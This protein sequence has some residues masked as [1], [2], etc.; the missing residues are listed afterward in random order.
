MTVPTRITA[1]WLRKHDACA[2]QLAIFER[3]WPD[4]AEVTRENVERAR[5]LGLDLHWFA[6]IVLPARAWAKYKRALVAAREEYERV[7]AAALA[8]Y[9]GVRTA[10]LA[11]YDCAT[12]AAL[13]EYRAT[14]AALD[15][16]R[17]T[18]AAWAEYERVT[19]AAWAEYVRATVPAL[20]DALLGVKWAREG[21]PA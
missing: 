10:A 1:A 9:D 19:D 5:D 15:E 8:K 11:K 16:Y 4:G 14:A 17:A 2:D 3:E 21:V 13:D 20:I 6:G 18:A 7:R 12:A